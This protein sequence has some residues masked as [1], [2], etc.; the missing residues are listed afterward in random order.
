[1]ALGAVRRCVIAPPAARAL[2][3]RAVAAL[4]IDLAGVDIAS[5]TEGRSYVLEVNG[6]VDFNGAYGGNVFAAAAAAL[7]ERA[8]PVACPNTSGH[9]LF[10]CRQPWTPCLT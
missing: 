7:L 2:A 4:G 8:V 5:D 10:S 9:S 1:V 6:A 3:I